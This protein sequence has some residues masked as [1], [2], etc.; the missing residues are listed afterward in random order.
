MYYLVD[1][2]GMIRNL[3]G[4]GLLNITQVKDLALRGN[5][6]TIV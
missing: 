3:R 1:E 4:C 6:L 2:I 5:L